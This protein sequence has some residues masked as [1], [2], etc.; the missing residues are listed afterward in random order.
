MTAGIYSKSIFTPYKTNLEP[1]LIYPVSGP[2]GKGTGDFQITDEVIAAIKIIQQ[3]YTF[4][5]ATERYEQI[6]TDY[7][8]F[9]K[10]YKTIENTRKK[11]LN[12]NLQTL[13]L[14]TREGLQGA[15]NAYSLNYSNTELKL[16]RTLLQKTIEDILAGINRTAA[17]TPDV[18][19]KFTVKK[20]FTLAPLFSYYIMLYGMPA[21]GVGFDEYKLAV[22]LSIFEKNGI[23]P[24]K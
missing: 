17:L 13:Y 12:K 20:T 4:N 23:D 8:K 14:I 11:T 2:G 3:Q 5:L 24:Y 18:G 19:G 6:P 15:M 10:L 22:L 21:Y 16:E 1:S 7:L 9:L